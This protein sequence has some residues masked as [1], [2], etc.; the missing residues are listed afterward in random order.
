MKSVWA[1]VFLATCALVVVSFQAIQQEI[2]IRK[3][4]NMMLSNAQEVKKNE[5]AILSSKTEL[6]KL[7]V[8]LVPLDKEKIQLSKKLEDLVKEKEISEQNMNTCQTQK[9]EAEQHR[10]EK[11]VE[12][13]AQKTNQNGEIQKVQ[14]EVQSLQ[15][16]I[17]DRDTKICLYVDKDREEGRALCVDKMPPS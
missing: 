10:S 14:E 1:L 13:D 15:K 11:T 4:R 5:D 12:A 3:M 9:Q 7:S 8:Q 2:N 6:Q 16:Q 17:L